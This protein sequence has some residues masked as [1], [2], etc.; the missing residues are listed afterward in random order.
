M[1]FILYIFKSI[2]V[3][4]MSII[5]V[6]LICLLD[7]PY[8]QV[9]FSDFYLCRLLCIHPIWLSITY[10]MDEIFQESRL[11][12]HVLHLTSIGGSLLYTLGRSLR[13]DQKLLL[14]TL[15]WLYLYWLSPEQISTHSW[16]GSLTSILATVGC[17][18]W[19]QPLVRGFIIHPRLPLASGK[20][21]TLNPQVGYI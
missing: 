21:P 18:G 11:Y 12:N 3:L 14:Y 4:F 6:H 20:Q 8:L 10:Q 5:V 17:S 19:G 7:T 2:D 13:E 1:D 9:Y 16:I 15:G